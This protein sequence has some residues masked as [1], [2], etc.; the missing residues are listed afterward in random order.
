M[1]LVGHTDT[2][3]FAAGSTTDQCGNPWDPTRTAG[4]S[5]AAVAAGMVPAALG[6]DTAGSLRIPAALCGVSTLKPSAGMVSNAGTIPLAP[7]LDQVGRSRGRWP[8]GPCCSP[9]S[10]A[11]NRQGSRPPRRLAAARHP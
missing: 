1:V 8:T 9:R 7:S 3:E 10:P 2:H 11:G 6:T 5:A 4:G